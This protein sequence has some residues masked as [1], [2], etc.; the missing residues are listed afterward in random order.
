MKRRV[1]E[2]LTGRNTLDATTAGETSDGGLG[3]ALD[4]VSENLAMAF[5][6][7]F[8][9]A[10]TTFSACREVLVKWN[11]CQA[12]RGKEKGQVGEDSGRAVDCSGVEGKWWLVQG[13]QAVRGRWSEIDR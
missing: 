12:W 4:V 13:G 8:A 7:T 5:G 2:V 10:L 1:G 3:N 6:A 9:E 11:C